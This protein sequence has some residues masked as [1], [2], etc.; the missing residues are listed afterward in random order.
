VVTNL[1]KVL[2]RLV[3]EQVAVTVAV[4]PGLGRVLADRGQAEQVL[5]NLVVNA[6]DAMLQPAPKTG[7]PD[8]RLG[9]SLANTDLDQAFVES[10]PGARP[11]RHVVL[12]VTDTGCGMDE[13]TLAHIFEPFFTTKEV[14]KG[15]GLGLATVYGIVQRWQGWIQVASEPGK[16]TTFR[17][18]IPWTDAKEQAANAPPPPQ[19]PARGKETILLVEDEDNVRALAR[20]TLQRCGYSVLEARTGGE[21]L[22]I[23]AT[24]QGP[25]HLIATDVVL[26]C[27]NGIE[28]TQRLQASRPE[29]K[30][31]RVSGYADSTLSSHGIRI[32]D[33]NF[34]PKPFTPAVLAQK[35]RQILD[36]KVSANGK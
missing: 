14:G 33:V 7:R 36:E 34:L 10:N 12:T 29:M 24:Y 17:I 23:S 28:L 2:R 19:T 13:R 16:G 25:I 26:P 22:H 21:A 35:V 6:R 11:G 31:L 20:E 4:E 30:T 3:G 27:M 8:G 32:E 18:F 9:I 1:D 5:M 15:T